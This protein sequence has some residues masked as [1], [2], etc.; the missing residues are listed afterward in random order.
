MRNAFI[1]SDKKDLPLK[2]FKVSIFVWHGVDLGWVV[3]KEV[4]ENL[5]CFLH[6]D[7]KCDFVQ[8]PVD[9]NYSTSFGMK[10]I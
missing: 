7:R 2:L 6:K 1:P 3:D 4:S 9:G 10:T 8:C 5:S